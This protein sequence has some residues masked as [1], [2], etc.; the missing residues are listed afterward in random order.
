MWRSFQRSP[1]SYPPTISRPL[2]SGEGRCLRA[3]LEYLSLQVACP[4]CVLPVLTPIVRQRCDLFGR[5]FHLHGRPT[6]SAL[7]AY[8]SG[9]RLRVACQ[10]AST[11]VA[12]VR[13]SMPR[14]LAHVA[15]GSEPV[16][17]VREVVTF[18]RAD[19]AAFA[20]TEPLLFAPGLARG[21]SL[22][23]DGVQMGQRKSA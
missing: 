14:S 12:A 22:A 2:C 5:A 10:T 11:S 16:I 9:S 21:K 18:E 23:R 20:A 1:A 19:S 6:L 17:I 7:Q 13:A 8:G 4:D 15:G 3:V